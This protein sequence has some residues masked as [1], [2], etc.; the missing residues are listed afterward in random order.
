[1]QKLKDNLSGLLLFAIGI[2]WGH[3]SAEELSESGFVSVLQTP[4]ALL[5][6]LT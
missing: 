1:M 6:F 3:G 5:E 2:G 4:D